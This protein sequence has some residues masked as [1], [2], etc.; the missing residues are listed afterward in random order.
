MA[1]YISRLIKEDEISYKGVFDFKEFFSLVRNFLERYDYDIDEKE[2]K[3]E[4]SGGL[5]SLT[6]KWAAD[7]KLDDYNKAI[8]KLKFKLSKC[9]ETYVDGAKVM[10][11]N[12]NLSVK[13][14]VERD[15]DD[16]W[17]KS[18][19]KKLSM[20]LY[21]KYVADEKQNYVDKL[22]KNLIDNLKNEVKQY[23]KI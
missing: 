5:K 1:N 12:L 21:G 22:V 7:K 13:V 17:S 15:Y 2:Y 10:E 19:F 14:E 4:S 20:A 9:K 8:I 3:D 16:K 18:P 6:V 11:G 23:L